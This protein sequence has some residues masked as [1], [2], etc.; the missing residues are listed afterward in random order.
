MKQELFEA[1][2]KNDITKLEELFVT[3]NISVSDTVK[4]L[5]RLIPSHIES[6]R[7]KLQQCE[8]ETLVAKKHVWNMLEVL[9]LLFTFF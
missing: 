3:P 6:A 9:E 4:I 7:I 8:E 1:L 5:F 2:L